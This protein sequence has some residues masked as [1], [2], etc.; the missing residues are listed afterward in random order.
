MITSQA[1]FSREH[2]LGDIVARFPKA[3]EILR[4]HQVDFC[5]GGQRPLE[6]AVK[7]HGANAEQLLAELNQA[8][9]ESLASR[10]SDID[11]TKEPLSK[12]VDHIINTHHAYLQTALPE[13]SRLTTVV[14]R[15]H[16]A[17]HRELSQVHKLFHT[18]KM[19]LD[20]HLITEEETVFPLIKQYEASGDPADLTKLTKEI[21]Q[22]ESE[23]TGAGDILKELRAITDNYKVPAD[24][25]GTYA[26]A[27]E[28][29][30]ELEADLF[31]HIHLENNILHPRVL[32][33]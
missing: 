25:C 14:L 21:E 33:K 12:L 4:K 3:S 31:E 10:S 7:E 27:Y 6:E 17:N 28:Q 9:E 5:C 24:A 23:H 29:M 8:Y 32:S 20:Q 15:A 30:Q 22:L 1:R 13:L 11:W 18:L 16:G 2:K 26:K 19:E